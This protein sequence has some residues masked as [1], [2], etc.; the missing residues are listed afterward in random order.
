MS[1]ISNERNLK[2]LQELVAKPG[3]DV[4][5]DCKSRAPRWA[6]YN[7]GIFLCVSCA[8]IHR[9]LGVHISKVKSLTLDAWTKENVETMQ[10]VGNIKANAFYNPDEVR[11]PPPTNMVDSERDSELEKFIRAK[12]EFKRFV[13]PK[14]TARLAPGSV[15][16][17]SNPSSI[18]SSSGAAAL[19]REQ[20]Q[21]KASAPVSSST[22]LA[23]PS[24]PPKLHTSRS[25]PNLSQPQPQT[26]PQAPAA[27]SHP[28]QAPSAP[29]APTGG[30]WGDLVSLQ[31]PSQSSSLPLQYAAQPQPQLSM[32]MHPGS[33]GFGGGMSGPYSGATQGAPLG[34]MYTGMPFNSSPV[35]G[36]GVFG[37]M[38]PMGAAGGMGGMGSM[39]SMNSFGSGSFGSM[40]SMNSMGSLGSMH[41]GMSSTNPFQQQQQQQQQQ[42]A[43]MQPQMG[44]GMSG[45]AFQ[46]QMQMPMNTGMPIQQP[47]PLSF[48]QQQSFGGGGLQ[49]PQGAPQPSHSAPIMGQSQQSFASSP[50]PFGGHTPQP[51]GQANSGFTPQGPQ[52]GGGY[53]QAGQQQQMYPGAGGGAF[54]SM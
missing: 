41:T 43:G 13:K 22:S 11:H 49:P 45:N 20:Q 17:T 21:R 40:G 16:G 26:Q 28:T 9:K 54:G 29:A 8:S 37:S 6:S 12:Y 19:Q 2:I 15:P 53:F 32:T 1:K 33:T 27:P 25:N 51:F 34:N 24:A 52:F 18:S 38:G 48:G 4:C 31:G 50:Q 7:L 46:S 35:S 42:F 23:P 47:A 30:V 36:T 10:K 3:N 44:M 14:S 5:A 39:D